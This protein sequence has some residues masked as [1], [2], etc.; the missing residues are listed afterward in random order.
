MNTRDK[1][2]KKIDKLSNLLKNRG[3]FGT[4][5]FILYGNKKNIAPKE[6]KW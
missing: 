2:E 6:C 4:I 1:I 5:Q 3:I